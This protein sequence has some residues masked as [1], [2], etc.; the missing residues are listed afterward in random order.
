MNTMCNDY[1]R[2]VSI[3]FT[4]VRSTFDI[5]LVIDVHGSADDLECIALYLKK[6]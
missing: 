6:H 4:T 2:G 3:A 5:R 1:E